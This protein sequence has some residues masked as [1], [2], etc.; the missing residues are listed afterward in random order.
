[1]LANSGVSRQRIWS[2]AVASSAHSTWL[3]D[4]RAHLDELLAAHRLVGGS[5]RGRRWRTA[6]LNEA[7]V[8]R[9][10]A[11]FQGFARDL[12]D[13]GCRQFAAWAAPN[14]HALE[15]VLHSRLSEA[16]DLDRGNANPG[17]IGKDFGRFGFQVWPALTNRDRASATH[18]RSLEQLNAV[19]NALAHADNS[20]LTALRSQGV[21]LVLTTYKKWQRDLD[22]LA[23]NLDAELAAQLGRLFGRPNPW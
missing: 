13:L 17:S 4:R 10:A 20:A 5:G 11:E 22:A 2:L 3:N 9:L 18:L 19:R 8:L 14:N 6:A 21:A 7:L 12:H 1:M 15:N 23:A 16:R